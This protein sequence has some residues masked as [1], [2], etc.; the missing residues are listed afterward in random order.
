[1]IIFSHTPTYTDSNILN[2]DVTNW[3]QATH[4]KHLLDG[5][6][7]VPNRIKRKKYENEDSYSNPYVQPTLG[8][9]VV[10]NTKPIWGQPKT[11]KV[12]DK[13]YFQTI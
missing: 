10:K 6:N 1:M 5:E 2:K 7:Q 11:Y 9:K 4:R 3:C 8:V 13:F 12:S